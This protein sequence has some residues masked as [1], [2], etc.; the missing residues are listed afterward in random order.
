MQANIVKACRGCSGG[1]LATVLA[2]AMIESDDMCSTD[3]SK[4]STGPSAN[5][6]PFNLNADELS[7]RGCNLAYAQGLGQHCGL[8]NV[9]ASVKYVLMG[10]RGSQLG[11]ACDFLN[12]HR[13][14]STGWQACKSNPCGCSCNGNGC[15]RYQ[16]AVA[17][18]AKQI[19]ANHKYGTEGYRV[20]ESVQHISDRRLKM[21]ITRVDTSPSGIPVYTWNYIPAVQQLQEWSSEV[22]E[23]G[24]GS[25]YR[26]VMAQDLLKMQAFK[27]AVI[28]QETGFYAVD[29]SQLDVNMATIR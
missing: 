24:T 8:Y 17:D 20:C 13:D 9:N 2:M 25:L 28:V 6:S 4:G 7:K 16:G 11:N 3:T 1:E 23:S 26:G 10:L 5:F 14:G 21:N 29:Y 15:D 12:F 27:G 18:G 22:P 19:L